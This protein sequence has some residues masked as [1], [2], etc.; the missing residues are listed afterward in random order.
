MNAKRAGEVCPA[1]GEG[2]RV[3]SPRGEVLDLGPLLAAVWQAA[4]GDRSVA[5][6]H[7]AVQAVDAAA[8]GSIVWQALDALADADLLTGRIAPHD[9]D[10]VLDPSGVPPS[11]RK[12]KQQAGQS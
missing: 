5:A 8:D 6:L 4:D 12:G 11:C 9:G 10:H 7:E 3:T 2:F 1:P